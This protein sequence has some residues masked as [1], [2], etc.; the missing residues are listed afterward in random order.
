MSN[1]AFQLCTIPI[2]EDRKIILI[3]TTDQK[4]FP[5][6]IGEF[7]F[8]LLSDKGI[9]QEIKS[10]NGDCYFKIGRF[11][12]FGPNEIRVSLWRW[13]EV[14]TNYPGRWVHALGRVYKATKAKGKWQVTFQRENTL[15][16]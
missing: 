11:Q 12:V 14:I 4:L 9:E 3:E 16:S 15:V 5:K 6:R 8:Q 7:G 1:D 2:V 10:N 13:M